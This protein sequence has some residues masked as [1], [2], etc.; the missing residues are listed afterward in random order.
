MIVVWFYQINA[1]KDSFSTLFTYSSYDIFLQYLGT[2]Y[3]E[4]LYFEIFYCSKTLYY[5]SK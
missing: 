5:C 4:I 2:I 3:S 1:L